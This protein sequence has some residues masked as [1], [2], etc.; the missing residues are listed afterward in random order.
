MPA[1]VIAEEVAA[2]EVPVE[3]VAVTLN[4]Y[5]VPFVNGEIEQEVA[6]AGIM[7]LPPV[8]EDVTV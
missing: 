3:L 2:A 6:V 8:G 5:A 4:V 1:G 7:Q